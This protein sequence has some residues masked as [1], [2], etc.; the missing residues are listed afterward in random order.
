MGIFSKMKEKRAKKYWKAVMYVAQ[1]G[2]EPTHG[3]HGGDM[4]S[5]KQGYMIPGQGL[6]YISD[7]DIAMAKEK[8]EAVNNQENNAQAESQVNQEDEGQSK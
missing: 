5:D 1:T 2:A 8:L 6:V 3:P 4:G 7:A